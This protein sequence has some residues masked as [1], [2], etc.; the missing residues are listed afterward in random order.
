MNTDRQMAAIGSRIAFLCIGLVGLNLAAVKAATYYVGVQ[1]SDTNS[2]QQAQNS[3]TPWATITHASSLV[4][5]GDTVIVESGSYPSGY[6]NI[7]VN[8]TKD[9]PITFVGQSPQPHLTAVNGNTI[10]ISKS[11][12]VI[13]KNFNVT[14]S[15]HI[16]NCA[17][18]G[19]GI[20]M[21]SGSHHITIQGCIVHD[22][23]GGGIGTGNASNGIGCDYIT[24][25]N[26]IV[27]NNAWYAL[28]QCSGI[29]FW[30]NY[31]ADPS[32]KGFH[33]FI[34]GNICYGNGE[35]KVT[36]PASHTDGNA[37]I[38]DVGYSHCPAQGGKPSPDARTYV[39]YNTCYNNGGCGV[40][41]YLNDGVVFDHNTCFQNCQD[42]NFT[43]GGE[44]S[45]ISAANCELTNNIAVSSGDPLDQCVSLY[46]DGASKILGNLYF[47][48]KVDGSS[49]GNFV[50]DPEFKN[51]ISTPPDFRILKGGTADPKSGAIG[52]WRTYIRN[53]S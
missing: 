34:T 44:L 9:H 13:V 15:D 36:S 23:G 19:N 21:D 1:G 11:S 53:R 16:A 33:N 20:T 2:F 14:N 41:V 48:G 40:H 29:S 31:N 49:T 4:A 38:V 25:K 22:C 10:L 3:S 17:D 50:G 51:P 30:M 35:F 27:Y 18:G 32:D 24:I 52:A 43:G 39:G 37:I 12:Y 46:D 42:P 26:N 45:I 28:Y 5:P 7:T 8:G 6:T 47:N